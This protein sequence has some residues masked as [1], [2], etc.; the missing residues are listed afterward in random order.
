MS[1][2]P[3]IGYGITITGN[4]SEA[5]G[6]C[7]RG[8]EPFGWEA[9][10]NI[11]GDVSFGLTAFGDRRSGGRAH[12]RIAGDSY[13]FIAARRAA[14]DGDLT[15]PHTQPFSDGFHRRFV[16][17]T[18]FRRRRDVHFQRAVGLLL[19]LVLSGTR[20]DTDLKCGWLIHGENSSLRPK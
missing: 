4:G 2:S 20:R 13:N 7:H 10:G 5:I 16:R 12:R 14:H 11:T 8:G 17:P 1:G 19:N 3:A 15:P 9:A 6:I 18:V